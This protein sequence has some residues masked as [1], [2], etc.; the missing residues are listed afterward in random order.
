MK[1][2]IVGQ[3]LSRRLEASAFQQQH[4]EQPESLVTDLRVLQGYLSI[5]SVRT[6]VEFKLPKLHIVLHRVMLSYR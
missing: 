2:P 4:C 3:L 1:D 5:S 6:H